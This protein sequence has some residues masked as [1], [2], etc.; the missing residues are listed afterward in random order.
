MKIRITALL[1]TLMS[2]A[3]PATAAAAADS[4]AAPVA[5]K[6][7]H[8]TSIH[9][10]TL[11]DDYFW[12]REKTNPEVIRYLEA[13]NAWAERALAPLKPLREQLYQEM[14]GRIKQTDLSVPYRANGYAYYSRTVEGKQYPIHCRKKIGADGSYEQSAEEILLDVNQLAEG[15]KFMSVGQMQVS[16][17]N[18]LMSFATD[19]TGY[20]QYTLRIKDLATGELL[21][22]S[23]ERVTSAAWAD[24]KTLF[25]VTEDA[26][27]KRSN[28]LWRHELDSGKSHLVFEE[29][30]ELF[31]LHVHR[32]RSRNYLFATSESYTSAEVRFLPTARA[33]GDWT[34]FS[35]RKKDRRY[36]L[37]YHDGH[38]YI[39]ADD[40][41]RNYRVAKTKVG[42][43]AEQDWQEVV[44]HRP[45]VMVEDVSMFKNYM[46]R[47][48]R[49][50]GLRQLHITDLRSGAGHRIAFPE[51]VY[52][53][54]LDVNA[55]WDTGTLRYHYQS[56]ATPKSVYDYDIAKRSATLL[57]RQEVLGDFD[58]A[59]YASERKYAKAADGTMIPV[60][61]VYRKGTRLDGSAPLL[62]YGYGS[63]GIPMDASFSSNRLSL[64]DRGAIFAIAHIRGGGDLGKPWHDDGKLLKKKNSFTD[65]ITAAEYLVDHKYTARDRLLAMGGSAGG[66]LVGA[67]VNMRPDLFKGIVSQ[68]PFVDVMNTMLDASLP[69]TVG[70]YEEW[71]NPNDKTYYD[72][73]KSYSPYDNLKKGA[74]PA[75]LV[76][77][78]LN[79]SQVMY[80]EPAK[81][82]ARLR[83]LKTDANPL[84]FVTNMGAGH[85]GS[86]GRY[87][88]LKEIALEYAFVLDQMGLA[89]K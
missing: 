48:E 30:D 44:A 11:H 14:L 37:S 38:F 6:K 63:Y 69:L 88:Y 72:Y 82:V 81:Y 10:D 45:A 50:N 87:D 61:L 64:L 49:E 78:G 17:N 89:K 52:G 7:P 28:Q 26:T 57:K 46:V 21:P 40:T 2:F 66:L 29:K 20:R 1:L 8:K 86:S 22:F 60:S 77:T 12:L 75:M 18:Q 3:V 39:L 79:D 47:T 24:D 67:V 74:Y 55:E 43:H 36:E 59:R 41:G 76:R 16:T 53:A 70:E 31:R 32:E 35:P 84:L 42:R 15:K 58:P 51:P 68:V 9:G 71:G 83:T 54:G 27:T 4:A 19:A 65:F 5:A 73:M 56:L 34:V 13:E 33:R 23:A 62:L 25:Y 85:G 80:W